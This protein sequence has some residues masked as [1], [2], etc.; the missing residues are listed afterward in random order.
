MLA[1][2]RSMGDPLDVFEASTLTAMADSDRDPHLP[3]TGGTATTV[4]VVLDIVRQSVVDDVGEIVHIQASC[5]HVGCD[6]E[7]KIAYAELL[8][9]IVTLCLR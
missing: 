5:C 6:E 2:D 1:L 8:H 4:G 7:L 9:H 3:S